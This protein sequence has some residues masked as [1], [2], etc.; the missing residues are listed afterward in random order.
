[1]P[2]RSGRPPRSTADILATQSKIAD[3]ALRLF[4]DEGFESVSIRR[5]AKEAGCAPMTIYAH[6]DSKVDILR[7][8][9]ADVFTTLFDDIQAALKPLLDNNERLQ[10]TAEMF[11][12]YWLKHPDHFR[13]VF[14]SNAVTRTD[15]S[16]F[17]Q[18]A[19]TL[20]HF[21]FFYDL[22]RAV[23][24]DEDTAKPQTDALIA[25]LIG[26]ALSAT[27]IH[28]Y[29]WTDARDMTRMLVDRLAR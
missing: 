24:P 7:Y 4:R 25:G 10:L 26:I 28:D 23:V 19:R 12:D 29:P 2:K 27:T 20:R 1:M 3:H 5:L 8:L 18:D 9:W 6:F 16:S 15:V 22:V 14:M 13:L 11:T 17:V 21:R